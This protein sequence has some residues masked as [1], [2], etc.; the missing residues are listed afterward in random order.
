MSKQT[1]KQLNVYK[2][3]LPTKKVAYLR[4]LK[5]ADTQL[6]AKMAGRKGGS[7]VEVAIAIQNELLKLLLIQLDDKRLDHKDKN[8]LDNILTVQEYRALMKVLEKMGGDDDT[9]EEPE[10]EFTSI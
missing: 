4:E 7:Q 10:M 5:I 2:V 3:V 1:E 8:D 9:G 6:A